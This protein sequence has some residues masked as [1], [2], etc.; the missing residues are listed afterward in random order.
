M[1]LDS[2]RTIGGLRF[3]DVAG[4]Q[5]WTLS[6]ANTLTLDAGGANTP[7]ISVNQNTAIISTPLSGSYGFTETG[8]GTLTLNGAI[9]L[10]GGL[11]VSNGTVN[12]SGGTSAFGGGTST[13]GY[14][15]GSGNLT[16]TGGALAMSG[17]L[18][19]GG[20]DQNGSQCVA[21][22]A[23]TVAN[24]TLSVGALTVARGNYLDNTMSG[25]VT[26]NSGG[27]LV[28][29]NDATL[30]FAG[31]G[32]GKLALNGGN[33]IIGPTA[34]K[35]LM[36]GY[37]DTGAGE[38]DITNGNVFL[39]NGTSVKMCRSGNTGGNVVNQVGGNVTFYS[40][41][42]V[43]VGGGGNLDL[44][45]AGAATSS[46]TY[47]LNGGTLT[48]P[49]ITASSGSG[50]SLF[51]FNG[52]TL[53]P[54]A[55]TTTFLQ[56]LTL[57]S[58][59]NNG[60]KIDTAGWNITVN[61]AMNHST[62]NGDL[63]M[64]GGLTK[65]GA[66]NLI[67][68]GTNTYTG[69]TVINVGTLS[70]GSVASIASSRNISVAS[71]AV[72]DL[73]AVTGGFVLG[74]AQTLSGS[75]S[76]NGMV[77]NNGTIQPGFPLGTAGALTF[78]NPPVLSGVTLMNLDRNNGL[79]LCGQIISPSGVLTY[80]GTLTVNNV[81]GPLQAGDAF[82]LFSAPDYA[83]AFSVTSLPLLNSGLA[84]SNS[85]AVNGILAVVSTASLVPTNILWSMSGSSLTLSWPSDHLGWRL[86]VQ[87]NNLATGISL[88]TNDWSA[89][90]NSQQTNHV[91]LPID[92]KLP[93]EFYRLIFP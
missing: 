89:V 43:T 64:D 41:A 28:S 48:V 38:L 11:T 92:P 79:P 6:G 59:R 21:T 63:A 1:T 62:I 20:S 75:G 70:L 54:T 76:V 18:R 23:V 74:A 66:G 29:T 69:N 35:W 37:Y 25:T 2:A 19:V 72:L 49:T 52:G 53:K 33:F 45:Y 57:A 88:N 10:G 39:D 30:D 3:G 4:A 27:T 90:A 81:G 91:I 82:Q 73:S 84:W 15:T 47:N 40:D 85:L 60:A 56:G 58:I 86:L 14:L 67:L 61:Q 13:V 17:E 22:G 71:G 16:M 68:G 5:T 78:S 65:N 50:A 9:T 12:I 7:S 26:L 87:T 44:N 24:A 8:G 42:G 36:V 31:M 77:T 51:N 93:L 46:N 32:R 34:T 80:G 55:S 83:E